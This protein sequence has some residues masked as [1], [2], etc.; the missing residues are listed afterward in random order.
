M[1]YLVVVGDCN[2][3]VFAIDLVHVQLARKGGDM[4]L[5]SVAPWREEVGF[6]SQPLLGGD[7]IPR[8]EIGNQCLDCL[9]LVPYVVLL[10]LLDILCV[11]GRDNGFDRHRVEHVMKGVILPLNLLVRLELEELST[12]GTV[13]DSR[14]DELWFLDLLAVQVVVLSG[15]YHLGLTEDKRQEPVLPTPLGCREMACKCCELLDK[16]S[17]RVEDG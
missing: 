8:A 5:W 11:D 10:E 14:V 2:P 9:V 12:L 7:K 4:C 3:M 1:V 16:L 17:H 13:L 15:R 6:D